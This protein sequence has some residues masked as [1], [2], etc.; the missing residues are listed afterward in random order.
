VHA[1]RSEINANRGSCVI[2]HLISGDPVAGLGARRDGKRVHRWNVPPSFD[3]GL[4]HGHSLLI[5]SLR[6][7]E[8][9]LEWVVAFAA[10]AHLDEAFDHRSATSFVDDNRLRPAGYILHAD[11]AGP[12]APAAIVIVWQLVGEVE[13][14]LDNIF[15]GSFS[16]FAAMFEKS[17]YKCTIGCKA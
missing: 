16:V 13:A 7:T 5:K 12:A 1:L 11:A 10:E 3:R 8:R 6:V 15:N 9:A 17:S 2:S 4:D 14:A